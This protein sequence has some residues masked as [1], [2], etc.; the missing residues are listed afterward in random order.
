MQSASTVRSEV[1]TPESGHLP[2]TFEQALAT[3]W[4]VVSEETALSSDQ[5]SRRGKVTLELEGQSQRLAVSYTA[6]KA[7]FEFGI[8]QL[9]K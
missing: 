2:E 7:G 8:P 1:A 4:V 5:K 3:G 9:I 6:T